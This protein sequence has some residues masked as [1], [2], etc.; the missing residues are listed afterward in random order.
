VIKSGA[1]NV[2]SGLGLG[3]GIG[4][5]DG[6]IDKL[7]L[8]CCGV[9]CNICRFAYPVTSAFYLPPLC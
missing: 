7:Q 9:H 2:A 3:L 5:G 6:Q 1:V 8:N 4:L